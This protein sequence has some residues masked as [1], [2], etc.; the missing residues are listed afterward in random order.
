MTL[1]K[2]SLMI[3]RL[4]AVYEGKH[5]Y[6][7]VY[8]PGINIIRG[9]NS[10]GKS[11]ITDLLFYSLGGEISQWK[12]E[13]SLI[14]YVVVEIK[15]GDEKLTLKRD[16]GKAKRPID[17]YWGD[18]E[19]SK[20]SALEDWQEY[21]FRISDSKESFSQVLF[22]AMEMPEVRGDK[23]VNIT[24]HQILRMI[25]IDQMTPVNRIIRFEQFDSSL[26]RETIGNLL[27]GIYSDSLYQKQLEL[28][29][30]KKKFDAIESQFKN[31]ALILGKAGEEINIDRLEIQIED[32]ETERNEKYLELEQIK[33]KNYLEK[34]EEKDRAAADELRDNLISL[35]TEF[36]KLTD[37]R[38][39]LDFEIADSNQFI[40]VIKD[41]LGALLS[42]E[43]TR[44]ALYD[45]IFDFCPI[46][47]SEINYDDAE[48]VCPLCKTKAEDYNENDNILRLRQELEMQVLE[49]ETLI[50]NRMSKIEEINLRLPGIKSKINELTLR[51]E[52]S[53]RDV[54][55]K[56][57]NKIEELLMRIGYL[58]RTLE[59]LH[60]KGKLLELID[61]IVEKKADLNKE[62]SR[63]EDEIN[64]IKAEQSNRKESAWNEIADLTAYLLRLDLDRE[65]E[66]KFVNRVSFN[67]G[68]DEI[69]VDGKRNFSASSM[70]YLKNSFHFA[71]FLASLKNSYFNYPRLVIFDNI[72]DKGMEVER[73]HNFQKNIVEISEESEIDHQ[74]IFATS[75]IADELDKDRYTVGRCYT[76]NDKSL[77][78]V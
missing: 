9:E 35:K 49:S 60:E 68:D 76:H 54:G 25:Y 61:E 74:I 69:S 37:E 67:F 18:Y 2:P 56:Y 16:I 15:L 43:V 75:M 77:E 66:F 28:D 45:L 36:S 41:R 62:I 42:S 4:V 33:K 72:E 73:T 59:N 12:N 3:N 55:T 53:T 70:V 30:K 24:M 39:R 7:E 78:F 5:A 1:Y 13:A 22:R 29:K 27:C 32:C 31:I 34:Y 20:N 14:D 52:A 47:L 63:L 71:L 64:G 19:S 48:S 23:S 57:D 11:T 50:E 21:P 58:D 65:A 44:K 17:I 10:S 51:Y 26:H 46:C 40:K 8:R 38:E 6:D